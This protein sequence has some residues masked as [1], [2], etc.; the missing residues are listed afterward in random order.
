MI[1]EMDATLDQQREQ[2]EIPL[3]P[4]PAP[5]RLPSECLENSPLPPPQLEDPTV[6]KFISD[7]TDAMDAL[8]NMTLLPPNVTDTVAPSASIA[9][10]RASDPSQRTLDELPTVVRRP[11]NQGE[12]PSGTTKTTVKVPTE[13]GQTGEG[14]VA[15]KDWDPYM[16]GMFETCFSNSIINGKWFDMQYI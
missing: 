3:P 4:V 8:Q 9:M 15:K 14:I 7:L 2:L 10:A 16:G 6:D 11:R 5:Q 13:A 1:Q 12:A